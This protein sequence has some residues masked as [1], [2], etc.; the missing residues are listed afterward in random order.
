MECSWVAKCSSTDDSS[1]YLI[2]QLYIFNYRNDEIILTV[3][4]NTSIMNK[5][6]EKDEIFDL[7]V[8][9]LSV[10]S[11]HYNNDEYIDYKFKIKDSDKYIIYLYDKEK[12][13]YYRK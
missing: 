3:D 4:N 11:F 5:T 2:K 8:M 12:Q 7:V 9:S 10:D 6:M 13:F 1:K